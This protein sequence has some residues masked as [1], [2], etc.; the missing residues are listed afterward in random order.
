MIYI[1]QHDEILDKKL[2]IFEKWFQNC[3]YLEE[4][5]I[6]KL[7]GKDSLY[8][9]YCEF[10]IKQHQ[11]PYSLR[12]FMNSLREDYALQ[13]RQKLNTKRKMDGFWLYG[14]AIRSHCN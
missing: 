2:E 4:N 6:I 7:T 5:S 9:H 14:L 3:C 13:Y 12:K 8:D 11:E 1:D 10:S